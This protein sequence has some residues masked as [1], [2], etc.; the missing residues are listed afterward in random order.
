MNQDPIGLPGGSNLYRFVP[1]AQGWTDPSGFIAM[2]LFFLPEIGA[3]L[4]AAGQVA[5]TAIGIGAV[6]SLGGDTNYAGSVMIDGLP[7]REAAL[8][9]EKA[10][11]RAYRVANNGARPPKQY[12]P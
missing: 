3:V 10:Q 2:A 7:N 8:A 9:W 12:R 4:T 1:N 6:L 11:V 5:L